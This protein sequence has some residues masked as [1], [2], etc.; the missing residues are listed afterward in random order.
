MITDRHTSFQPLV[1]SLVLLNMLLNASS[2]H[3]LALFQA[4]GGRLDDICFR[5]LPSFI[6]RDWNNR[7]VCNSRVGEY[8]GFQL[9]RGNL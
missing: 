8:V 5:D 6:I 4:N 9:C 1:P 7:T 3:T 2:E